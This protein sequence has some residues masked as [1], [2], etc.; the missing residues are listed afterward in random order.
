MNNL[1]RLI[2]NLMFNL[3]DREQFSLPRKVE[4]V[5]FINAVQLRLP[6]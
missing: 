5:I 1:L 6:Y 4:T 3:S 2:Q